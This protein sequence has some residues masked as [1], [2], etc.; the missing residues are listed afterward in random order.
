M[1]SV[2]GRRLPMI[3]VHADWSAKPRKR[4]M[5][6]AILR[7]RRYHVALPEPVGDTRT[8]LERV[9]NQARGNGA[10]LGLDFPIGIPQQ[11]A[12]RAGITNFLR[13][14]RQFGK[15]RWVQFYDIAASAAEISI[16]R[17]FYPFRPGGTSRAH[18][19]TALGLT[20][21]NDLL[22]RCEQ[23][24]TARGSACPLFWTL[25]GNQVGR[26]AITGWRDVLV[27][28]L[29]RRDL[30]VAV[31]PFDGPLMSL[32]RSRTCVFAETYPADGCVQLGL[33]APGANATKRTVGEPTKS[34]PYG[35]GANLSRSC[36]ISMSSLA[37]DS[38]SEPTV[39][40]GSMPLSI[41]SR[42]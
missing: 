41:C 42:C 11:Y 26:A 23:S 5:T 19:W 7:G 29:R 40:T 35:L 24:Y 30:D 13:A 10:V 31:W 27:P 39:R 8:L 22:R 6:S 32:I 28:A 3:V 38:G 12:Q 4:W 33:S 21:M 2:A 25:G 37:M 34:S 9:I 16:A 1:P 18:L 36:H 17:T 14:L 15:G 20:G